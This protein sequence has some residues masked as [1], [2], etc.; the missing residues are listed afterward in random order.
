VIGR[1]EIL[2]EEDYRKRLR[3]RLLKEIH[4]NLK[5][6]KFFL[7]NKSWLKDS[8]REKRKLKEFLGLLEMEK[9]ERMVAALE[10]H[11]DWINLVSSALGW[12]KTLEVIILSDSSVNF[13]G[14]RN[15]YY[16]R[17]FVE[18]VGR[19]NYKHP[20]VK[21]PS[22]FLSLQEKKIKPSKEISIGRIGN[23]KVIFFLS[24]EIFPLDSEVGCRITPIKWE[25][26]YGWIFQIEI[27]AIQE[28]NKVIFRRNYFIKNSASGL[29]FVALTGS[30]RIADFITAK[31]N[32]R[33][34][35]LEAMERVVPQGSG[36]FELAFVKKGKKRFRLAVRFSDK[37]GKRIRME[38]ENNEG[39][40]RV[41]NFFEIT[42][43]KEKIFLK[44]Y[45]LLR[46]G[47]PF[48]KRIN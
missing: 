43:S 40:F 48:L 12:K 31:K 33:K 37:I 13:S 30:R 3:L 39:D 24:R 2:S 28:D 22:V 25:P 7:K 20:Q 4:L 19:K 42:P 1:E 36:K 10:S 18:K 35:R 46:K 29:H 38:P 47:P 15:E 14:L 23:K 45:L 21:F 16:R 11:P 27:S 8:P 41:L 44:K 32:Y 6:F 9:K 26:F 34:I 5:I 17:L